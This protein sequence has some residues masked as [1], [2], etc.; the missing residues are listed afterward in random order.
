MQFVLRKGLVVLALLVSPG[1]AGAEEPRGSPAEFKHLTF[2][3]IGP[4]AGGRVVRACGIPGDPLTCYAATAGGGVWK[5][6]DGGITWKPIFDDQP[7]SSIGSI[8]IAPSDPNVVYVGSGEANI[9]GNVQAG[10]GIYKSSDAGKTWKHVWKQEGQIGTM[11]V[12]PTNP[13]VAYAAVFGHAFGPNPERGVYRTIDGGKTWQRVLYKDPGTG[14]SDICLDP[15]NPKVL[16]TGLWQA[17]RRPWELTSGGPGSGL[18]ASRDGGDTWTQLLPAPRPESPEADKE[19]PPGKKYAKGLPEGLWGKVCIA[20]AASDGRRVYAMIEA[21]KGGLFRSDDGGESWTLVNSNH[22]LRARPW[23]FSTLP[24]ILPIATWSGSPR[25]PSS[26]PSMG[27]SPSSWSRARTMSITTI[28]GSIRKTR[29]GSSTVTTV[30]WIYRLT[31]GKRGTPH[32]CRS[33]SSITSARTTVHP[34]TSRAA[35]RIWA[36]RQDRAT[37]WPKPVSC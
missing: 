23:Y 30:V 12:H 28:S 4:S 16:F 15:S 34:T 25:S 5:S 32:P 14:A 24:S 33:A 17:R 10:N 29:S 3:S 26:K 8:A 31:A 9:R 36:P 22:G 6:T 19:A 1:A 37:A 13:E 18:Y 35:C 7:I 27:A 21:E 11:I 20:V 2:R